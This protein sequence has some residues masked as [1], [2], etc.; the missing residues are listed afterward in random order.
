LNTAI[1]GFAL[2]HRARGFSQRFSPQLVYKCGSEPQRKEDRWMQH[3][4]SYVGSLVIISFIVIN[5]ACTR[6]LAETP[7]DIEAAI[8][9]AQKDA[10]NALVVMDQAGKYAVFPVMGLAEVNKNKVT[11]KKDSFIFF[12]GEGKGSPMKVATE[13]ASHWK[14]PPPPRSGDKLTVMDQD[15][16]IATFRYGTLAQDTTVEVKKLFLIVKKT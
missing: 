16:V 9:N 3:P 15:G 7:E 4:R 6:P 10:T 5:A 13:L 1:L 8:R 2:R 12:D 11:V 14:E